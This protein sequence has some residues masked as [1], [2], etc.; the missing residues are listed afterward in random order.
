MAEMIEYKCP[1]CGGGVEF[2]ST[3]QKMKCPYCDTEFTLEQ[4][5]AASEERMTE[6]DLQWNTEDT[7]KW[8][9]EETQDMG[10]YVCQSCGGEIVADMTTGASKCPYCDNPV[11]FSRQFEGDLKPDIIIPFK[12]DKKA[13]K[14]A[15]KQHLSGKV[16][17]PKVFK[18]ENH[19]DE[20]KGVYV[21]F[22][23]VV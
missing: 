14:A 20:I 16:L 2:N 21:P 15:L 17:L 9:E 3:A 6:D 1:A 5:E 4:F 7:Q 12:L 19:L 13:A 11:V 22:W 23:L 10:I 8:T 18:D